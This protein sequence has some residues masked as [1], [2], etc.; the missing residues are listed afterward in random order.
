MRTFIV[1][2]KYDAD[3]MEAAMKRATDEEIEV[4]GIEEVKED[5]PDSKHGPLY[6]MFQIG[7]FTTWRTIMAKIHAGEVLTAEEQ[8]MFNK[9]KAENDAM[10]TRTGG[11]LPSQT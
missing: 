2:L 3:S 10:I 5:K 4:I 6:K 7:F 8:A 9:A 1:T 11:K